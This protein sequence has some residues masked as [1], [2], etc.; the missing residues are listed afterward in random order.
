MMHTSLM[1]HV[2]TKGQKDV[3]IPWGGTKRQ[4][5][6]ENSARQ[7]CNAPLS[8]LHHKAFAHLTEIPNTSAHFKFLLREATKIGLAGI[9]EE[10]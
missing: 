3:P 4:Q 1:G 2:N 7:L 9:S 6:S 10:D 8:F 5:F